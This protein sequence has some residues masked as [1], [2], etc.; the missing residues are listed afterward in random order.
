MIITNA[1]QYLAALALIIVGVN[2]FVKKF[3][4]KI[5]KYIPPVLIIFLIVVCCNTIRVLSM[6][7]ETVNR[8]L[9][10]LTN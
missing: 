5:Y 4:S 8:A 7:N 9:L 10:A 6:K 3:P 1:I 2:L